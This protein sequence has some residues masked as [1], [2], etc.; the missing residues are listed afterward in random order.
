MNTAGE[1]QLLRDTVARQAVELEA[2][3]QESVKDLFAYLMSN[4]QVPLPK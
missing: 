2:L 1:L 3:G 4:G